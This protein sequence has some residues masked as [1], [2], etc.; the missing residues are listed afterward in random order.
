MRAEDGH[1]S[2]K[3]ARTTAASIPWGGGVPAL[4]LALTVEG[5][6]I[7]AIAVIGLRANE[8]A[9]QDLRDLLRLRL[10]WNV[11]KFGGLSLLTLLLACV[12][13]WVGATLRRASVKG[14]Q[15]GRSFRWSL[16][17]A[18]GLNALNGL[19]AG[20]FMVDRSN[21]PRVVAMLFVAAAMTIVLAVLTFS[22]LRPRQRAA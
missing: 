21:E 6:G 1:P 10:S 4:A 22:F 9:A 17:C 2:P 18:F 12:S 5:L 8:S 20:V 15:L 16:W 14:R 3:Q 11:L 19:A 7:L 13:V